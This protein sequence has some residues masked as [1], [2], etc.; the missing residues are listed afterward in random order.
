VTPQIKGEDQSVTT[1]AERFKKAT[2]WYAANSWEILPCHGIVNG[3][4][5][6]GQS[7]MESKDIGKHPAINAWNVE[8]S[9]DIAKVSSWWETNGE[10]NVGVNCKASGFLVIDI[11][12]RS[13]GDIAYD[14]FEAYVDGA[15]PPTV[16]ATTGQYEVNGKIIRG[17]HLFYKCDESEDLIGNLSKLG[18][19]GI[20]VKHNGYVLISPS[21]HF[22]GITYEWVEG[23]EPWSIPIAEAPEDLLIPL[24]KNQK[25]FS[26]NKYR[27][28]EW[29]SLLEE[30]GIERIDVEAILE[31]G[32]E[33]GER[34]I[35]I[36]Q[37]ACSLANKFPVETTL[38]KEALISMMIRF[39]GEKIRPPMEVDGANSVVMH[40]ER[41]IK[42]VLE[43]PIINKSFPKARDHALLMIE[44]TQREQKTDQNL[45]A[46]TGVV[47]PIQEND[48]DVNIYSLPGTLGGNVLNSLNKGDS[49]QQA[50]SNRNMG[51]R[52]DQDAIAAEDMGKSDDEEVLRSFSDTGNGRRLVDV[53]ADGI[54]YT[55]GLGW[56]IWNGAFWKPDEENL[57][58]QELSKTLGA[59]VAT[60]SE[61]YS[62]VQQTQAIAWAH[63]ARS[64]GRLKAAVKSANSDPRITIDAEKWDADPNLI[65]TLNGV[66]DL[67]TGELKRG[68]R[69]LYITKRAP[70]SYTRGLTNMRW[71]QFLDF[72]TNGDKEYQDWLQR[73]AGYSMSGHNQYDLMFL[74]YGPA[75]SGKNTLVESIVKCLG[76]NQYSYAMDSAILAADGL[77]NHNTDSY[78][79]AEMR[80]R[81]L[82]W[83][84]ELPD[85]ER[86]K[87]NSVKKLT[88]SEEITARSPGGKP[89]TFKSQIKVWITTNHRPIITDDAMWRRIRPIPMLNIPEHSDPTLKEFLF[90]PEGGL[91]AIF[92]WAVEG[93]IKVLGS[94]QR[95]GLGWCKVVSEAAEM[96]RKNED[97]IALFLDEETIKAEGT[98]IFVKAL[99]LHYRNWSEDRGER[100]LTQIGFDRKLRERNFKVEGSGAKAVVY[101]MHRAPAPVPTSLHGD[102]NWME[103]TRFVR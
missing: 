92:S 37:V 48:P 11:D 42:F 22:S 69:K 49:I 103:A 65:G 13:G 6:C 100:P 95:D 78:H 76:S 55:P 51:S 2:A 63:Q 5:T 99:F 25:T 38:G 93:A 40:T 24:R 39:N 32:I 29:G 96:Y 30:S 26:N 91:P 68:D 61:K 45:V 74:V 41:A 1:N 73:A 19:K 7:H 52:L 75:G 80:G 71:Q 64:E 17:R 12:P 58:M 27:P 77:A 36:F 82:A 46:L 79:W 53:F 18:F 10:Y 9:S 34:A 3:R 44:N 60:E 56:F 28:A 83:A 88:G 98:S 86:L 54:R 101:G 72:A 20:D 62:G 70:V 15:L 87:E 43:N 66:V 59:L 47:L 23:K 35:K 94:S 21:R 50:S 14:K 8:S 31:E 97:R 90:D 4:C 85:N 57:H 81:R 33:E 102:V 67:R 89:F 16:E 84:D